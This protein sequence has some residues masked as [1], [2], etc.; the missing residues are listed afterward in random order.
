MVG[1]VGDPVDGS[2]VG[3]TEGSIEGSVD[4]EADGSMDGSVEGAVDGAIDGSIEGSIDGSFVIGDKVNMA[5]LVEYTC[6]YASLQL[7][8][9]LIC[10]EEGVIKLAPFE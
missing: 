10:P 2:E 4:G 7:T 1:I 5:S 9:R 6:P 8:N 3:A